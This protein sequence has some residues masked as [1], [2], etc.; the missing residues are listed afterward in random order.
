MNWN[1]LRGLRVG[2]R[3]DTPAGVVVRYADGW[4]LFP[5]E[6]GARH[7]DAWW[8]LEEFLKMEEAAPAACNQ[9]FYETD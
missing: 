5:P 3:A 8:K 2:E 6:G 7:W 1:R 4:W 9:E